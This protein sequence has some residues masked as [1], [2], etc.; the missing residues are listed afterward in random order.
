MSH[1]D[2]D[3]A[4]LGAGPAGSTIASR[5]ARLGYRV[6]VFEA[7]PFPR[8]HIGESLPASILPLLKELGVREEVE[9]AGFLRPAGAIVHW[10][11]EIRHRTDVANGFQVDRSRF[12][13]I[14]LQAALSHGVSISQPA[15]VTHF[16]RSNAGEWHLSVQA[17][18]AIR[19]FACRFIVDAT[20]K[21]GSLPGRKRLNLQPPTLALCAYWMDVKLSG[22]ETLIE[23]STDQWYWGAPLPDGSV[24]ATVFVDPMRVGKKSDIGSGDLYLQLLQCSKLLSACCNGRQVTAVQACLAGASRVL[25]PI[26]DDWLKI[27]EAA[28]SLDPLSSQGVQNAI[29]SGLQ[30]AAI[31]NTLLTYPESRDAALAFCRERLTENGTQHS[32]MAAKLYRQQAVTTPTS[33]WIARSSGDESSL[34]LIDPPAAPLSLDAMVR[35]NPHATWQ[36]TPALIDNRIRWQSALHLPGNRPMA[37]LDGVDL[38]VLLQRP[39][40]SVR[41]RDLLGSWTGAIGADRAFRILRFLYEHGVIM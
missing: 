5:L 10:A 21:K 29:V 26:G 34:P 31:V 22:I 1:T 14:L 6:Q 25:D 9:T 11:G 4:V 19:S 28:I 20:G 13:S 40:E 36:P 16:T 23:A 32:Q 27:G 17:S 15:R 41:I 39:F 12:D 33:F 35:L 38:S 2:A 18:G 24:N 7:S 3:V 37:W 8:P 30:G